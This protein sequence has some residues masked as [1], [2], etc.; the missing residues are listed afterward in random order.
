MMENIAAAAER[1]KLA[2]DF[3]SAKKGCP[4]EHQQYERQAPNYGPSPMM[5]WQGDCWDLSREYLRLTDPTPLSP[6]VL[7]R[8]GFATVETFED[9]SGCILQNG[10][11]RFVAARHGGGFW[12]AADEFGNRQLADSIEPRTLG[13]LR[14]LA[15]R[16]GIPLK[17]TE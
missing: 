7:K 4:W 14:M 5:Q 6:E 1:L 16:L 2:N 15:L 9:G 13:E 17:E 3:S 10:G 12:T 11:L 8:V